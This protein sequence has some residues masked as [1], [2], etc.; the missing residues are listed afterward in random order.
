M[1]ME[2]SSVAT[3]TRMGVPKRWQDWEVAPFVSL[4]SISVFFTG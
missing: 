4:G 2:S 1:G 3:A